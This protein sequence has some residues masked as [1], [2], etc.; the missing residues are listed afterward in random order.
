M[1]QVKG[2]EP[3]TGRLEGGHSFRLSYTRMAEAG[4]LEP[5]GGF[6]RRF[7]GPLRYQLRSMLPYDVLKGSKST[8]L[9]V[10][11]SNRTRTCN[12][13]IKSRVRYQLRHTPIWRRAPESNRIPLRVHIA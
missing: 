2:L 1:V 7:S 13:P 4:G 3:P 5:P 12:H 6:P 9:G 8:P 11:G 10:G